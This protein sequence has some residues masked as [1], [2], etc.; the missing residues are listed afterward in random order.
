MAVVIEGKCGVETYQ[1]VV[2]HVLNHGRPRAPRGL[3]TLD[4][5]FVVVELV[6]PYYA[7]PLGVGRSVNRRIAAAEAVQLIGGFS[8]PKLLVDASPTFRRFQEDDGTFHGAYGPRVGHQLFGVINR[9]TLDRDSRQAVINVWD[10]TRDH[11]AEK[12]DYPCTV[13]LGFAIVNDH[14]ELNVT[15]RSNDVWLGTPYDWFQFTQLQLTVAGVLGIPPGAYRHTAWS[16]HVYERDVAATERLHAP[17]RLEWQ[18]AGLGQAGHDVFRVVDRARRL[19]YEFLERMS[20]SE[21]WYHDQL[22]DR[23]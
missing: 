14:L 20:A 19:P 10:G 4:A 21:R 13:A 23:S 16:L 22:R 18:P 15:M 11:V 1:D 17:E 2:E 5:G 3:P 6:Q 8:D 7:L 9:L 12:R